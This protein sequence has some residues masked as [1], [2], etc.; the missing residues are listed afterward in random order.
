MQAA[1]AG[2]S[3]GIAPS[4]VMAEEEA[5]EPGVPLIGGEAVT[6][7]IVAAEAAPD[8]EAKYGERAERH[9]EANPVAAESSP[10]GGC[11]EDRLP[12]IGEEGTLD[13]GKVQVAQRRP[14]REV[15]EE[16]KANLLVRHERL[17]ADDVADIG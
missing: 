9:P 1:V 6:T 13:L 17:G 14:Q 4:V 12:D 5:H 10:A 8:I 3:K 16:G 7:E 2:Q 11:L 15:G